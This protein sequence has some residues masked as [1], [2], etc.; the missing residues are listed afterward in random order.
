MKGGFSPGFYI[1]DLQPCGGVLQSAGTKAT[2]RV[3]GGELVVD[4][5][6]EP[7]WRPWGNGGFEH[8]FAIDSELTSFA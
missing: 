3:P 8:S 5:D 2:L 1:G 7:K 6:H 4:P